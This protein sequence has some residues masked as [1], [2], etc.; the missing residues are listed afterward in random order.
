MVEQDLTLYAGQDFDITYVV[1]PESDMDLSQYKGACKIRKRPYDYMILELTPVIQSKQVR[2]YISGQ[3]SA[4][5]KIKGGD[6]IYDA[7]LYNDER[8]L[9]IGQGTITIVPDIS[10]HD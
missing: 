6:Y 3:E 7:F 2:F 8:W 1:P 5:K 9:K 4:E 10:M